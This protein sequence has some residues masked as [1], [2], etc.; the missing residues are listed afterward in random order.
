MSSD[1]DPREHGARC[2]VCPLAG[3]PVVPPEPARG[4]PKLIIVGEGPGG[5]EVLKRRP[6]MGPS[7]KMVD[8]LLAENRIRRSDVHVTNAALCRKRRDMDQPIAV[9]CCAPRLGREIAALPKKVPILGLG[10]SA[11][12]PLLGRGAVTRV[13]GAVWTA[14]TVEHVQVATARR[15]LD[16]WKAAHAAKPSNY[17]ALRITKARMSMMVAQGRRRLS[18]R[19]VFVT[20]HPAFL[21]R[22]ADQ[23]TPVMRLDFQRACQWAH[24]PFPLE[25]DEDFVETKDPAEARKLLSQLGDLVCLDIE[26]NGRNPLVADITCIGL[27]DSIATGCG[28]T[29]VLSPWHT[30][31]VP[32]LN[33]FLRTRTVVGHNIIAFDNICC[34]KHGIKMRRKKIEDSLIAHHAYAGHLPRSLAHVGSI[35]CRVRP[36]KFIFKDSEKG[37]AG[38]GIKPEDLS[39]YNAAD[40]RVNVRAW[41]RMQP[42]LEPE[43]KIYENDKRVAFMCADM[44][45]VGIAIDDKRRRTIAKKLRK[46]AAY[47]LVQMQK[48][49]K[50]PDF[51][52]NK[53]DDIREALYGRFKIPVNREWLTGTGLPATSKVVLEAYADTD[54][55]VGL[56]CRMVM[57]YRGAYDTVG[58]YLDGDAFRET[59]LNGRVHAEWRSYGTEVGRPATHNPNILNMPRLVLEERVADLLKASTDKAEQA[60]ILEEWGRAAYDPSTRVREIYVS[61]PGHVFV[62]FDLSQSQMRQAAAQSGDPNFMKTCQGDVHTGNA[63]LLFPE[64]AE[65]IKKDPGYIKGA[66]KIYRDICKNVGFAILFLAEADK[67]FVTLR[68]AGFNEVTMSQ[69]VSIIRRIH[70]AYPQYVAYVRQNEALCAEQGYLRSPFMGRIRRMGHFA[71]PTTIANFPIISGEAD[72]MMDRL[73]AI[74]AERP[75]NSP[76]VMWAYDAAVYECPETDV[77]LGPDGKPVGAMPDLIK[78]TFAEPIRVAHNGV[79]FIQP[80]DLKV[81]RRLSDL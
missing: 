54:T 8:A 52:P 75:K 39:K 21:L 50:R 12:R 58:E 80:I 25:D 68:Q 62:Y 19:T 59:I 45:R 43:R 20:V 71:K 9:A 23:W 67:V 10:G 40:V 29:V 73:L 53:H 69:V 33:E 36:W 81:G 31:L 70:A 35:Y 46:K 64:V 51:N 30:Q 42:D 1:Y 16:K 15:N 34:R 48:L 11:V 38:A 47:L 5:Y 26:T 79:E 55:D 7:G 14:P 65:R 6:F 61:K 32:V 60:R 3:S 4:K 72:V 2:D 27:S 66:G 37:I 74:E 22:G 49:I 41:V 78:R 77:M 57:D 13:R 17:T 56:F 28:M 24:A 44:Q 63:C 18:G 76:L